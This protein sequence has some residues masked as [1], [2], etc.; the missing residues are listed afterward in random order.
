MI[1]RRNFYLLVSAAYIVAGMVLLILFHASLIGLVAVLALWMAGAF[2]WIR[3]MLLAPLR[4][5]Q[6]TLRS[7]AEGNTS[8]R[9]DLERARVIRPI[10]ELVNMVAESM[11]TDL[12]RL[13]KLERFRSEFLGNVSHELRTPIFSIQGL[14]ETLLNGAIDDPAVNRDF[15]MR[16][17]AN[18]ERLNRL[19]EDLI[20]ISRVESGELKLKFRFFDVVPL[21]HTVIDELQ[22]KAAQ[23]KITLSWHAAAPAL[24]AYA[25]K[26]RIRQVLV[27]LIDNALKYSGHGTAV[28]VSVREKNEVV[29]VTVNDTGIGIPAEHLPRIFERFYRIEKDRSR[30]AGGTGLGLAIAKH[31]VEAHHST[32]SVVSSLGK[33]TQFTFTLPTTLLARI[34]SAEV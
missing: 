2:L 29:E 18:T 10:G 6:A 25:D 17:L 3:H 11:D 4:D 5:F 8:L 13:K 7:I 26:E 14:L 15:L 19:L 24:E 20:D 31:I 33:G 9:I 32:I 27:N 34:G 12:M 22:E 28:T 30:D 1:I 16:A 21:V 23:Q